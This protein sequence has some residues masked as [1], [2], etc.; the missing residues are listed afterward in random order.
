[1]ISTKFRNTGVFSS[2]VSEYVNTILLRILRGGVSLSY[3]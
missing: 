3:N 2:V 1:M